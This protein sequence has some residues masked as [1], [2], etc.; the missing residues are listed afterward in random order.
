MPRALLIQPWIHDFAAYDLWVR[1]LGLLRLGGFLRSHGVEVSL[2]DCLDSNSPAL[3]GARIKR[4]PTGRGAFYQEEIPKPSPLGWFPRRYK[5]YG[6]PP[7]LFLEALRS[8]P[9]PDVI[10]MGSGMTYWYPGVQE[11]IYHCRM[12]FPDVP[13]VLGGIYATILPEHALQHSG[14][15]MVITGGNWSDIKAQLGSVLPLGPFCSSQTPMPAWDLVRGSTSVCVKSSEGCPFRCSYCAS[16]L[17][18]PCYTARDPHEVA[19]EIVEATR[20]LGT[21]DVAFYDDALLWQAASHLLPILESVRS[22]ITNPL[23]FH[24]PNGLH[25]RFIDQKLAREMRI[26]GFSTLR[27]G[28]ESS[29]S[30]FHERMG[31]KVSSSEFEAAVRCLLEAGYAPGDIGV[32]VMA[33]LPGQSVE[34]VEETLNY[35]LSLGLRPHLAEYSP[36]PGTDLWEEAVAQSSLPISQEPLFHNNTLLPCRW[37]RFPY[38]GFLELKARLHRALQGRA[39]AQKRET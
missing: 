36:I 14:A 37:E 39:S 31:P 5:R 27:L 23:R 17:L 38:E 11:T 24:C 25:A 9:P 32:Y 13:V 4:L 28:L 12:V 19:K 2:L 8:Q 30:S 29:R 22:Q 6:I 35:V 18:A 20:L 10:L 3:H 16:H 34:E 15:D 21:E 1:P 33:G 7:S 26:H